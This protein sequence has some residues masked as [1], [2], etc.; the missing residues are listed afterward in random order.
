M[1]V[2]AA[3]GRRLLGASPDAPTVGRITRRS[4]AL[5]VTCGLVALTAG[6]GFTQA[7]FGF[8]LIPLV[9]W[10]LDRAGAPLAMKR[11]VAR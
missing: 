11:G 1:W 9:A 8:A 7:F 6:L 4:C 2:Y 3:R 5:P 10:F